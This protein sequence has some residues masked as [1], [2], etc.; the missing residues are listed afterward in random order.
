MR[1]RL[2]G[3]GGSPC[4]LDIL[5]SIQMISSLSVH[6][7]FLD[8][9]TGFI[10]KVC[11]DHE[12]NFLHLRCQMWLAIIVF[13]TSCL[14][15]QQNRSAPKVTPVFQTLLTEQ[16]IYVVTLNQTADSKW[17]SKN[18][19]RVSCCIRLMFRFKIKNQKSAHLNYVLQ[20]SLQ[21]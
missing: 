2:S 9:F 4:S 7:N 14:K 12:T 18:R 21:Q 8:V 17:I 19:K 20:F 3:G 15:L 16:Q 5:D 11:N 1:L 6:I 13:I 10:N